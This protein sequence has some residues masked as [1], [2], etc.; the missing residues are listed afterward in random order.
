MDAITPGWVP[1]APLSIWETKLS[2]QPACSP[3]S[4][5]NILWEWGASVWQANK[6]VESGLRQLPQEEAWDRHSTHFSRI[7]LDSLPVTL[8]DF[9][10]ESIYYFLLLSF[11]PNCMTNFYIQFLPHLPLMWLVVNAIDR[12]GFF[13]QNLENLVTVLAYHPWWTF[14]KLK[15]LREVQESNSYTGV[16]KELNCP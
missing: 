11:Y 15:N 10:Q 12:Y 3:Q 8:L 1:R 14:V 7:K 4:S 6:E 9:S 5:L 16:S 13:Q 2:R